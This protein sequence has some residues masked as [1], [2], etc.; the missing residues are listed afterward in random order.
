[1]RQLRRIFAARR[2]CS[3]DGHRAAEADVRHACADQNVILAAVD[4]EA[5]GLVIPVAEGLFFSR[6]SLQ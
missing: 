6:C 3:L 5:A 2:V 1:M 4:L